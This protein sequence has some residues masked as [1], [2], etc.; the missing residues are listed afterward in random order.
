V[1]MALWVKQNP[2]AGCCGGSCLTKHEGWGW[3]RCE[4]HDSESGLDHAG[5][6]KIEENWVQLS[7]GPICSFKNQAVKVSG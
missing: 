7:L 3:E 6:G 4:C 5:R 2:T 1:E